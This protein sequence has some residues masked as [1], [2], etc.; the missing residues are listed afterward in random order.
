MRRRLLVVTL[1]AG[2][3]T[4]EARVTASGSDHRNQ[5]IA[6]LSEKELGETQ[7]RRTIIRLA[8]G[9]L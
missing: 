3:M 8:A 1:G 6:H 7:Q 5:A 2:S 4:P 9:S